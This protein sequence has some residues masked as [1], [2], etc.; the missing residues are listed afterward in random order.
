MAKRPRRRFLGACVGA[1]TFATGCSASRG[2]EPSATSGS[3]ERIEYRT[4]VAY[5]SLRAPG[6][7]AIAVVGSGGDGSS[8]EFFEFIVQPDRWSALRFEREPPGTTE[9]RAFAE[10][11]D[12]EETSLFVAQ[13]RPNGCLEYDLAY[14]ASHPD[15]ALPTPHLCTRSRPSGVNCAVDRYD[16]QLIVA[17]LSVGLDERPDIYGVS[18]D[19][20]CTPPSHD[21]KDTS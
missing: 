7:E 20:S 2:E 15:R 9:I 16:T 12:F 18:V 3:T 1:L 11:T 19:E 8:G 5:R 13:R 14:V 17:R 6:T 21:R 10:Q 4:D